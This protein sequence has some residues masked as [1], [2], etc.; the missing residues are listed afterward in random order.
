MPV[1][2]S[3][4]I[5]SCCLT[6]RRDLCRRSCV[7]VLWHEL[8][9]IQPLAAKCHRVDMNHVP[10]YMARALPTELLEHFLNV[11]LNVVSDKLAKT[12]WQLMKDRGSYSSPY[13]E[14]KVR[15]LLQVWIKHVYAWMK[16]G[17]EL[18]IF[19]I[20]RRGRMPRSSSG[21]GF[22]VLV[23]IEIV[24]VVLVPVAAVVIQVTVV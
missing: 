20:V 11:F 24:V 8:Y 4:E 7:L 2:W 14:Q 6:N 23:A 12:V 18:N 13:L 21:S 19:L 16:F 9:M 3:G 10:L 15:T 1:A 22:A 17:N 5:A